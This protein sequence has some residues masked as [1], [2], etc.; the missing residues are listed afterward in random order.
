MS[1]IIFEL[2]AINLSGIFDWYGWWTFCALCTAKQ[3]DRTNYQLHF[4]FPLNF[5]IHFTPILN[6]ITKNSALSLPD[7][8][9]KCLCHSCYVF[10][11]NRIHNVCRESHFKTNQEEKKKELT[12]VGHEKR[13]NRKIYSKS[14]FFG[15]LIESDEH[16]R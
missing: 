16:V 12:F 3:V 5:C 7:A 8:I 14:K 9:H 1:P 4:H 15:I 6:C 2:L 13:K 10:Q 11:M